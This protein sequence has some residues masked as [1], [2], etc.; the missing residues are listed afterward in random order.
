MM[1]IYLDH[2]VVHY[3]VRGFP[4]GID[5][6]AERRALEKCLSADS[7][8][9]FV[10]TDWHLIEAARDCAHSLNPQDEGRVYADFFEALNPIFLEGHLALER[11]E[12]AALAYARWGLPTT[13]KADWMFASRFSQ[14]ALSHVSEML[15]DFSLPV[16]L[17]HLIGSDSSRSELHHAAGIARAGQQISIDAYNE[18][19]REDSVT[20]QEIDRQWFLSLIPERDSMNHWIAR[21]QREVLA[22]ALSCDRD[23]VLEACPAAFAESELT[24]IRAAAGGRKAKPQDAFD[25]M[26]L[27]PALAYCD[28]FVSNDGPLRKQAVE[29]CKRTGRPV[30]IAAT[31]SEYTKRA[32]TI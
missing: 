25:L 21:D 9:R 8:V 29:V 30:A 2:N 13:R 12:M 6:S 23:K 7:K 14:I 11:S 19:R 4:V 27:V 24:D 5:A 1:S 17:R 16:Y 18:G 26:H 31:L 15:V 3:Y 10:V 22:A 20:K 28:A 32:H